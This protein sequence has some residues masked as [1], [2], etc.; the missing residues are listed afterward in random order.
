MTMTVNMTYPC[1]EGAAAEWTTPL[2][3]PS[4]Q[5]LGREQAIDLEDGEMVID[6]VSIRVIRNHAR[7]AFEHWP[8]VAGVAGGAGVH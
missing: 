7:D 1:P 5:D 4:Q 6:A 2:G 3:D 8:G